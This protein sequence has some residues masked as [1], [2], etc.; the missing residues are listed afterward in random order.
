MK[1]RY[2]TTSCFSW[3]KSDP[4]LAVFAY[5]CGMSKREGVR[6]QVFYLLYI[7]VVDDHPGVVWTSTLSCVSDNQVPSGLWTFFHAGAACKREPYLPEHPWLWISR[8]YCPSLNAVSGVQKE[9][10]HLTWPTLHTTFILGGRKQAIGLWLVLIGSLVLVVL[11]SLSLPRRRFA[12]WLF[13]AVLSIIWSVPNR[14]A[15]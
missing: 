11:C 2:L 9:N 14:W 7:V 4:G 10:I 12:I 8:K 1:W 13:C 5:S 15:Y 6:K 3:R